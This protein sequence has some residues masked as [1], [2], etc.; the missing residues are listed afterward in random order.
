YTCVL[1]NGLQIETRDHL[2]FQ[3]PFSLACWRYICP[4]F[5]PH[6]NVHHNVTDLKDHLDVPFPMEIIALGCWSIWK[7]R[8]DCIFNNIRPSLYRCRRIFKEEL[9]LVFHRAKRNKYSNFKNW[10]DR[11]R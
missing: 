3:C 7:T 8:N 1:C 4:Q 9:N 5:N 11:F 6:N 10:I 2:F